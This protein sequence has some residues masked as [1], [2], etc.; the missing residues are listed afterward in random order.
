[1]PTT[2]FAVTSS[3]GD[4]SYGDNPNT[5]AVTLTAYASTVTD[6]YTGN[7]G[8][9]D[10]NTSALSGKVID[11]ATFNWYHVSYSVSPKGLTPQKYISIDGQGSIYSNSSAATAGWKS[12]TLTAGQL[13]W[14]NKT[15]TT[16]FT[17]G[18]D[19]LALE[20]QSKTWDVQSWDYGDHSRACYL[21]VTYHDAGVTKFSILR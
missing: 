10:I 11:S 20:A 8:V 21:A 12:V 4:F 7:I 17:F 13:A 18:V 15:G 1:M 19:L 5:N 3:G 14:I 9:A 16:R 2:N 6:P